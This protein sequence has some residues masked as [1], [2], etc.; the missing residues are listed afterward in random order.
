MAAVMMMSATAATADG[1]DDAAGQQ[2]RKGDRND[3]FDCFHGLFSWLLWIPTLTI[4]S[5]RKRSLRRAGNR[6][7]V[8]VSKC[9]TCAR[10]R[11]NT[12]MWK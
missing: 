12:G 6:V 5:D 7:R 3:K 1:K 10:A 8:C 9:F 4:T 2:R 11:R